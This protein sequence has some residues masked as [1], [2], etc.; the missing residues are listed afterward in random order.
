MN[1]EISLYGVSST[2]RQYLPELWIVLIV[3]FLLYYAVTDGY[4]LGIGII[5]LFTPDVEERTDLIVSIKGLWSANQ[6]WLVVLGGM[7]F[8][9]FPLFYSVLLSSLYIPMC[10]MLVGLIF[11]GIGIDMGEHFQGNRF[12]HLSFGL[13]SLTATLAQGFALGGLLSGIRVEQGRF[14]GGVW[15]WMN[16]FSVLLAT[17]VFFG[18]VMLG[19]SF[20]I[21]KL[22]GR[23]EERGRGFAVAASLLA[24]VVSAATWVWMPL[25]YSFMAEK[26]HRWPDALGLILFPLLAIISFLMYLRSIRRNQRLRPLLWNAAIILFSFLGLSLGL[27]PYMLP[28]RSTPLT[29]REAAGSGET[30]MFMLVV[31]A[32]LTPI[33]LFYHNY[34]Y[35]VFRGKARG[36]HRNH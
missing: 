20:I 34:Q 25:R 28:S 23:I 1:P 12:W 14:A 29:F 15:D 7:L 31:M 35:W 30:L 27:W 11:R 6:T 22:E 8:G 19:S 9:A 32:I 21:W 24:G 26:F 36:R 2:A 3:L 33:I 5:S 17:G 4:D 10:A 13:G 16:P 18:Y